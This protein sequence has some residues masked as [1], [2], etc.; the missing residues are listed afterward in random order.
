M[1]CSER[2]LLQAQKRKAAEEL[3][4]QE[5]S[6]LQ[7]IN[8]A[9]AGQIKQVSIAPAV[10]R[11]S[12]QHVRGRAGWSNSADAR[13]LCH[14]STAQRSGRQ[15]RLGMC[16]HRHRHRHGRQVSQSSWQR[17]KSAE[18]CCRSRCLSLRVCLYDPT[19]D[20]MC[21]ALRIDVGSN[22][23]LRHKPQPILPTT[24]PLS[25]GRWSMS[26]SLE[27]SLGITHERECDPRKVYLSHMRAVAASREKFTYVGGLNCNCDDRM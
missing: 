9:Q 26:W 20:L 24:I 7:A 22:D 11:A 10:S 2:K 13:P 12:A 1:P 23:L 21:L 4:R 17:R 8:E 19:S 27:S 14:H 15:L 16:R 3:Q 6:A 18:E 5:E 25:G